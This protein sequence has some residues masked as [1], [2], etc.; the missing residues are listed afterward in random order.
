MFTNADERFKG[1]AKTVIWVGVFISF[2]MSIVMLATISQYSLGEGIA[3]GLVYLLLGLMITLAIS[4]A[5]F[6]LGK[7]LKK[8]G[9]ITRNP[10]IPR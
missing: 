6:G 2:A 3:L 1:L 5:L 9:E 8:I 10:S 7:L 4:L